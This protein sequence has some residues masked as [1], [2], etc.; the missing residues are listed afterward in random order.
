MV[1]HRPS[2]KRE[3]V[4]APAACGVPERAPHAIVEADHEEIEVVWTSRY[5]RHTLSLAVEYRL[6]RQRE[7]V[8]IPPARRVPE[9]RPHV[10]VV[11]DDE[12]VEVAR[13]ARHG[14]DALGQVVEHGLSW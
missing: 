1:E 11:A 2:R 7:P 6:P 3:P 5:G 13:R 4:V 10:V 12:E 9:R 8:V 14:C